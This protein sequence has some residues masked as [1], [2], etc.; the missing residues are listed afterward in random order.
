MPTKQLQAK[1]KVIN[2]AHEAAGRCGVKRVGRRAAGGVRP[3][4]F[5][6]LS[7]TT[8]PARVGSNQLTWCGKRGLPNGPRQAKSTGCLLLQGP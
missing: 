8:W 2:R 3:G 7:F 1:V 4:R 6:R 5:Q